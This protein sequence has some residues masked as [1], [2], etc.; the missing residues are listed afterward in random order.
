MQALNDY[1]NSQV[2]KEAQVTTNKESV[3]TGVDTNVM[4]SMLTSVAAG[5]GLVDILHKK[6]REEK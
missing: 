4:G 1:L 5:L 3:H 2:T 6:R